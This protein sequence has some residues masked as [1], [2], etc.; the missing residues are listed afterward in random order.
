MPVWLMIGKLAKNLI[1]KALTMSIKNAP[2][3]GI[4]KNAF[5]EG[6]YFVVIAFIFAI[7]TGV[8]PNPNPAKPDAMT[9]AS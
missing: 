6:P 2:T 5:G 4:T 9:L 8:A 3:K 7:P 1:T